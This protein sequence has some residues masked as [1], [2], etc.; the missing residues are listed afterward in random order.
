MNLEAIRRTG[1]KKDREDFCLFY[2]SMTTAE[3]I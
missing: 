1:H 2:E 3:I